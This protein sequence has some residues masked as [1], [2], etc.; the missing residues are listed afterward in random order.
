MGRR[1]AARG[2]LP[3]RAWGLA[4]ACRLGARRPLSRDDAAVP[5]RRSTSGSR[6][7][8]PDFRGAR[9][10][11]THAVT[12]RAEANAARSPD[13]VNK[14]RRQAS[15]ST[16]CALPG[17]SRTTACTSSTRRSRRTTRP[18]S[19]ATRRAHW[20]SSCSGEA[21]TARR[22]CCGR[23]RSTAS[24]PGWSPQSLTP[25]PSWSPRAYM[26]RGP[27]Y[28]TRGD[29]NRSPRSALPRDTAEACFEPTEN[30][31]GADDRSSRWA[32]GG[33]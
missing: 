22:R 18:R 24:L 12:S 21:P 2:D 29:A 30:V 15:G 19:Q 17:A 13:R 33:D 8:P 20:T 32:R 16:S 5:R 23:E 25:S 1:K 4:P 26:R 31:G 10:R 6:A 11:S 9:S 27:S 7:G 28:T 14:C 3:R